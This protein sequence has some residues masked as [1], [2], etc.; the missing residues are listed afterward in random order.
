MKPVDIVPV[1]VWKPKNQESQWCNSSPNAI[2]LKNGKSQC[3]SS[4]LKTGRLMSQLKQSDRRTSL[5]LTKRS[6][7]C[8]I[9]TSKWLEGEFLT[10]L[11]RNESDQHPWGR[12]FDSWPCSV[13]LGSGIAM[14]CG[15]GCRGGS[16]PVLLWHR[17]VATALIRP[18][19][20]EPPYT[21]GIAAP[22][23]KKGGRR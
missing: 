15:V 4:S 11:S 19:A 21:A 10:W 9:Q 2:K 20:W 7:L 16:D 22:Q 23:D 6:A 17:L 5:L 3:P 14:S 13:G 1:Q 8:S 12:G 18:L